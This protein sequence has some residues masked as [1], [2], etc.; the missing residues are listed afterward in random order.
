VSLPALAVAS[1]AIAAVLVAS[2]TRFHL[3]QADF[4]GW[5][6]YASHLDLRVPASLYNGFYPIGYAALLRAIGPSSVRAAA[7]SS[8]LMSILALASVGALTRRTCG[9]RWAAAAIV[10]LGVIPAFFLRGVIPGPESGVVGF[11]TFG[12]VSMLLGGNPW[13]AGISLGLSGLWRHHGALL[14]LCFLGSGLLLDRRRQWWYA[15]AATLATLG[16]QVL[17]HVVAG[18]APWQTS[19]AF[20]MAKWIAGGVDWNAVSPVDYTLVDVIIRSP[21]AFLS[22]YAADVPWAFLALIPSLAAWRASGTHTRIVALALLV[23]LAM[24]VTGGSSNGYLPVLP[25]LVWQGCLAVAAVFSEWTIARRLASG[26]AAVIA[27]AWFAWAILSIRADVAGWIAVSRTYYRVEGVVFD[28]LRAPDPRR[29]YTDAQELYF[30]ARFEHPLF[31]G[32]W[33]R[34]MLWGYD[35]IPNIVPETPTFFA[36]L[37]R[38]CITHIISKDINGLLDRRW[39]PV[40]TVPP[41]TIYAR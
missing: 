26:V 25:L 27:A 15:S 39:R 18:H 33:G 3:G 1:W 7:F 4:W 2:A 38:A 22:R 19:Q 11:F 8:I 10:S 17:I 28:V 40:A 6:W 20:N 32:G 30:P 34:V 37:D 24:V 5:W 35:R 13:R 23:Y 16:I 14:A 12:A 21:G 36:G 9:P 31:P 29:V 41:Y